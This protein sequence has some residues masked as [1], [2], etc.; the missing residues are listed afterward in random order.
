MADSGGI[1]VVRDGLVWTGGA[2]PRL[3]PRHD[4]IIIDGAVATLEPD[5]RG[6]VDCEVDAGGCIVVPG[7][8]NA[9]VHPGTSPR[10]RGLAEDADIAEDGAYYHMTLP[11][12]MI[13]GSVLDADDIAAITEWDAVAMLLGGAT[14]IVG[15]YFG[16]VDHWIPIVQ[17]LGFRCDLGATYPS[18]LGAIGFMQDGRIVTTDAGDVTGDYEAALR[19]CETLDGTLDGRLST[20]LSPHGS[21]TVPEEILR[22]TKRECSARGYRAHL[23]LAQHLAERRTIEALHGVS[24]VRYLDDIG[25]LGGDVLATHVTYVDDADID[26]LAA[27]GT[28]V[29]HCPYRKA[30]EGVLSPF[31]EFLAAGVNVALATDSFSHDL[32]LDL[33]LACLLGKIRSGSVQRP[34]AHQALSAVTHGAATALGRRDLGTLEP[35]ARGDLVV[36]SLQ[37]PFAAPVFDPLRAL[38]YYAGAPDI[39][40]TMVD[41]VPIVRDGVVVGVDMGG[42]LRRAQSACDRL[43]RA[44]DNRRVLP[45]GV[46]YAGCLCGQCS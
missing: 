36:I 12:Q 32:M 25:F 18:R 46:R 19:L 22:A 13:A 28:H 44:A 41:G 39:R 16:P 2:D 26:L 37:T 17:R 6:R 23:H 21:D 20:H 38:V 24:S 4:V 10:S 7:L 1:T 9:H 27:S 5:Y 42:L 14:T 3:L 40:H 30:K 45:A 11:V 33:K 43:W 15:E 29:V 31:S 8:I 35:G 34:S